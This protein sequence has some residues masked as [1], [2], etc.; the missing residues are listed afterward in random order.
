M[1]TTHVRSNFKKRKN[2][3]LLG[4]SIAPA[5]SKSFT[6][7]STD[8]TDEH[9]RLIAAPGNLNPGLQLPPP[10]TILD[11]V[12]SA[13]TPFTSQSGL[14]LDYHSN[15]DNYGQSNLFIEPTLR[16]RLNNGN[17]V[18][19]RTGVNFFDQPNVEEIT[20]IP[21]Q[22]GWQGRIGQISLEA[23][24]GVDLF[25]RLPTA[26]NF[27]A[28]VDVPVLPNLTLSGAVEQSPYKSSAESL[29]NQITALRFGPDIYWQVDPQTSLFSLVRF[30]DYNDGNEEFQ[31]FTRLEHRIGQFFVAGNLFTWSYTN[32]VENTSGYFS[33]PD[34]LV[35]SGEVGWAEDISDDLRCRLTAALGQQRVNGT[36]SSANHYQAGCTVQLSPNTEFDLGYDFSN[37][38]NRNSGGY[39]S[40]ALTGQLR[41]RF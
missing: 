3:G 29:E 35:Y 25:D 12:S 41:I 27:N 22:V 23:A 19:F 11:D 28:R 16:F 10:Q 30:G 5:K 37:V 33:P 6:S 4:Q 13:S 15:S 31:S 20:N 26:L 14:Q 9:I 40:S 34:F 8:I 32:N 18:L 21:L 2:Q 1:S 36:W 17:V 24:A 38:R 39:G 7:H